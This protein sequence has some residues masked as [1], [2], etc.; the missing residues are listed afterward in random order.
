MGIEPA[1]ASALHVID[2]VIKK[3]RI[4]R[5]RGERIHGHTIGLWVRLGHAN[6]AA[7]SH[8]RTVLQPCILLSHLARQR[9]GDIG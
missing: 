4:F 3:V 5:L 9:G 1:V 7:K 2:A 8:R 6:I